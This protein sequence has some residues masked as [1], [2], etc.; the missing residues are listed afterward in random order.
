MSSFDGFRMTAFSS[1]CHVERVEARREG[2][3]VVLRQ[4]QEDLFNLFINLINLRLR[5]KYI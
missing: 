4:A 1:S 5:N 3:N 2:R